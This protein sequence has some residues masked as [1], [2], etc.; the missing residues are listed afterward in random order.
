MV[1]LYP[2][3]V[4]DKPDI[5]E[6]KD[7]VVYSSLSDPGPLSAEQLQSFEEN[8]YLFLEGF[9]NEEEVAR[10][11]KELNRVL[12][13]SQD[14]TS[15]R[16][17]RE[18]ESQEV[19]S[20]FE[21]H[22]HDDF[23]QSLSEDPRLVDRLAQL[24]GSDVYIH[25]SRINLKSGFV[26]KEFYWHSDFETWHVED[27]MP[28]MRAISCSI[29]LTENTPYNGPLMLVP[30][31]HKRFVSC[32]GETPEAHYESSLRKQEYGVPDRESLTELVEEGG[33]VAPTGPAGSVILFDCNIMHGSNSNISPSPRSNVFFVFNSVENKLVDP[34]SGQEPRPSYIA[35]RDKQPAK[36]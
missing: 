16:V 19:R 18:P 33:I 23:F 10:M 30:G 32:V 20:V 26:G 35:A 29:T 21:V 8:G 12:A 27:G 25:Q 15:K 7:P 34:F 14:S 4:S 31:S 6:R 17:I 1:D 22:K 9:F 5:I 11:N 28:R 24:L 13:E 36:V 3:R 2:S